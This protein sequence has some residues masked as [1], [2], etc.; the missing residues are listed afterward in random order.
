MKDLIDIETFFSF[1]HKKEIVLT[2]EG[3]MYH[4]TNDICHIGNKS[5]DKKLDTL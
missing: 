5:V 1:K 3:E 2:E 4:E